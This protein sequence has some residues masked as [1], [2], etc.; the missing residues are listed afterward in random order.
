M[1]QRTAPTKSILLSLQS[2][3]RDVPPHGEPDDDRLPDAEVI[4]NGE[5]I[6]DVALDR[7]LALT[8]ITHPV[9]PD[10]VGYS[11]KASGCDRDLRRPHRMT[12]RKAVQENHGKPVPGT[13]IDD[14]EIAVVDKMSMPSPY[15]MK[16]ASEA[17]VAPTLNSHPSSQVMSVF[18][19]T[20]ST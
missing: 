1:S 16:Y 3:Q 11:S 15:R 9:A 13:L 8:D 20:S 4:K 7:V 5:Q 19:W 17:E 18:F 14:V 10:V 6:V 12:E 2:A